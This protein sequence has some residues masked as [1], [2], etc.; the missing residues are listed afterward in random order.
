MDHRTVGREAAMHDRANVVLAPSAALWPPDDT[1]ESVLGANLHQ[2]AIITLRTG[3]NEAA[4][5]A[6][7]EGAAV[8]WQAGGQTMIRGFRRLDGSAYTTLPDVFVYPKPWDDERGS[9]H[10]ANDGPPVLIIEVL[11]R[12]TFESDLNLKRGKGYSYA[13]A[14]MREYLTLDPAY[15]Y[16]PEGG[17]GWRLVDGEYRPWRREI[18]GRWLSQTLPLAFGLEGARAAVYAADGRRFLREGEVARALAVQEQLRRDEVARLEQLRRD[19]V[20]RLEQAHAAE[21][22]W[23]R[24][25]LQEVER[26]PA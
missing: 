26:G 20:A 4:A 5:L 21:V 19:E 12:E 10:L 6:V 13:R 22:E 8:P 24:R 17:V 23:L 2:T 7:P 15:R 11:S 25:R 9:L 18:D 16:A 3:I 1:E 14:G